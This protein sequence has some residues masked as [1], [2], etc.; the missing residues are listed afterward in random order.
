MIEV[1]S[2]PATG[3]FLYECA[4]FVNNGSYVTSNRLIFVVSS[5]LDAELIQNRGFLSICYDQIIIDEVI[6]GDYFIFTLPVATNLFP[7]I[8]SIIEKKSGIIA[9]GSLEYFKFYSDLLD[10]L[11]GVNNYKLIRPNSYLDI[12]IKLSLILLG[13]DGYNSSYNVW[14]NQIDELKWLLD[15]LTH[16]LSKSH[17]EKICIVTNSQD[18]T[19]LVTTFLQSAG[20]SFSSFINEY[21]IELQVFT[22]IA[23]YICGIG[24]DIDIITD[25]LFL[26]EN[27]TK[28]YLKNILASARR[29][30]KL[31]KYNEVELHIVTFEKIYDTKTLRKVFRKLLRVDDKIISYISKLNIYNEVNLKCQNNNLFVIDIEKVKFCDFQSYIIL[32]FSTNWLIN[33]CDNYSFYLG[34]A[35]IFSSNNV[36]ISCVNEIP[37][38]LSKNLAI[39]K[40]EGDE[41]SMLSRFCPVQL[42]LNLPKGIMPKRVSATALELLMNDQYL[43]YLRYVLCLKEEKKE[44]GKISAGILVHSILERAIKLQNNLSETRYV[45]EFCS[46]AYECLNEFKTDISINFKK[47][48]KAFLMYQKTCG[49]ILE[50]RTEV[51]IERD[52]FYNRDEYVTFYASIDRIDFLQ[53]GI[54]KVIDYKT[55][56]IPSTKSISLGLMPQL[57]LYA[58]LLDKDPAFSGKEIHFIYLK[59][60]LKNLTFE[61]SK[62][63]IDLKYV[64]KNL[65]ALVRHFWCAMD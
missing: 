47:L 35:K 5:R 24:N 39:L 45:A 29:D 57:P 4:K 7:I 40:G 64:E 55:G 56:V 12:D 10:K 36:V 17:D 26:L 33:S 46:I 31:N 30:Y 16:R 61:E 58:Y 3:D 32:S 48:A 21:N 1:L 8:N 42:L 11:L 52:L 27:K 14:K 54:I 60:D 65:E 43:Y 18:H 62:I 34:L 9:I 37:I 28:E 63:E 23:N 13:K 20:V 51:Y 6:Y 44:D 19:K 38:W 49:I 41:G 22:L 53:N 25:L 2:I 59:I 15:N 50:S